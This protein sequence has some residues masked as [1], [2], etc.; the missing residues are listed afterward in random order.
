MI[1]REINSFPFF[2]DLEINKYSDSF[3]PYLYLD[4]HRSSSIG[5]SDIEKYKSGCRFF[6]RFGATIR[7]FGFSQM[8]TMV[9]TSRNCNDRERIESIQSAIQNSLD[10]SDHYIKNSKF[11]LYGDL[12]PYK[13]NR[14]KDF[15][16]FLNEVN[17]KAPERPAFTHH[18]LINYSEEWALN[19]LNRIKLI[20]EIS[21]VIR[22]TKG[23]VSG[24][25]IPIKMQKTV[26]VYS[27]VPSVSE[28]WSDDGILALFLIAL[29][30][31][32]SIKDFIG[33]KVYKKE[34]RELIH[35]RRDI[36]L[37]Y[38]TIKLN[39]DSAFHNRIISFEV[40]GPVVY[41]I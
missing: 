18:I 31:W 14:N 24:G 22:F 4:G 29:K 20:P 12:E 3:V 37:S 35:Q 39:L 36:D 21:S 7:K 15:Y 27:Q 10:F 13:T 1:Q 30:N 33:T 6:L 11:L 26:F 5:N 2:S 28:F 16:N 40:E 9:H 38:E 23:F 25:W 8:V 17:N 19:N 41:E 32:S 34:E